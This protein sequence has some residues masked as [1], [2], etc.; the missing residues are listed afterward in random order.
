MPLIARVMKASGRSYLDLD[1]VAVTTGP[2]SF[3]GLR[4]GISAAR[5]IG[6]GCQQTRGRAHH[7]IGLRRA[8][9]RRAAGAAVIVAIDPARVMTM[10]IARLS[11]AMAHR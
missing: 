7:I 4:V 2:G 8:S 1:R 11:R 5:G 9:G 3:H 10:F 6:S